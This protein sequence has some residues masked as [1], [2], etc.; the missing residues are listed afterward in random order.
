ME[1]WI[2]DLFE[3]VCSVTEDVF[4]PHN[5]EIDYFVMGGE[6]HTL[7][8]FLEQCNYINQTGIQ[9]LGRRVDVKKP[10]RNSLNGVHKEIL[11]TLVIKFVKT[12][13]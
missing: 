4:R 6:K 3:K 7:S 8:G 1:R 12:E 11:K 10:D 9:I 13:T 5:S 2:K